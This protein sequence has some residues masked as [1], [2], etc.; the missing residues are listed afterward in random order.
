MTKSR[1]SKATARRYALTG[2]EKEKGTIIMNKSITAMLYGATALAG[3][4]MLPQSAA[5]QDTAP[6]A[7][8]DTGD[9][10]IIVT[11]RKRDESIVDV[12]LAITVV[13]SE[14]MDRLGITST[15]DLANFVPGLQFSDFTPGNSRNDRGG[16]RPLIFRGLNLA[17]NGGITGAGSMFLDGAAVIGNEIPG[18]Y[19]IGAVEVLRGPQSVYFGRAAMTG[20]VSYRTASIPNDLTTQANITIA[21]RKTFR[22]EASI[23]GPLVGDTLG[24][25]VTGLYETNDGFITNA[26]APTG[27]KFGARSRRSVSGTLNFTPS[28]RVNVKLYANYFS[29]DDGV[30]ATVNIFPDSATGTGTV[31][32]CL[33][34]PP[35][36]QNSGVAP[37][38]TICGRVPGRANAIAYSRLDIPKDHADILFNVPFLKG[39]RFKRTPGM[40]RNVFNAHATADFEI[41]DYL[42][43]T[44]I[45]GYHTNAT[46]QVVDGAQ[47]PI[48]TPPTTPAS[49]F[50]ILYF[51]LSNKF[52][53]F[54][55]EF[56]LAS[57]PER[58]FSWTVGATY[59]NAT[60]LSNAL[61]TRTTNPAPPAQPA[62]N[63]FIGGIGEDKAKTYGFFAGAYLKLADDRLT[64]SGEARYQI[65]DRTT[66]N[67]TNAGWP[68]ASG[69]LNTANDKFRSFTPR[70][71]I[72]YDVGNDRKV[73]A[74]IARGSR[75]GGF[76]TGLLTFFN[77]NN[78]VYTGPGA[79]S[80]ATVT[81]QITQ[82][83]GVTS[84]SYK[85]ETLTIGEL[86]FKGN[87]DG[88]KGYFDINLYYG[89]VGSQ[90]VRQALLVPAL[91]TTLSVNTNTGKTEVYGAEFTGNYNFTRD[92]SLN[93]TFA[94]N[95]TK[96]LAY[97]DPAPANIALYGFSDYS[98][99]ELPNAPEISGS[100]VLSY[101]QGRS[102][103]WSP[104]GNIALVYRGRQWA[105]I[106]NL[107]YV[108]G[109]ATVD[110][111]VGGK[112]E[113]FR[114]EAFVTNLLDNKT[115][116][117]GNVAPDFG[118]NPQ[119]SFSGFYGAYADPRTFGA[120]FSASF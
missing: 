79:P 46:T 22:V 32:N 18:G 97:I 68:N 38:A 45:T 61:N 3:A 21:E 74:S 53:D 76:N 96:R 71:S 101:E 88:N 118:G 72:D 105:D 48:I 120:R 90:Q 36:A 104:F 85:E 92:I 29:D 25:R 102:D 20:A 49:G 24:F 73:Y 62:F 87:L 39:E 13:S 119:G 84:P 44:S 66:N 110:L 42:S 43:L 35:A 114:V 50:S 52:K 99:L 41:S 58:A 89:K 116:P 64:L 54:S 23:A 5:A 112:N 55:Q 63:P 28:D 95:H 11:A 78:P 83:F 9:D 56:R 47:Q 14:K 67:Y 107:A 6:A 93:T 70:A 91:N 113:K 1:N 59:V 80:F 103:E 34:G 33:K 111:R 15:E 65:D 108:P 31:T 75:P 94:W 2:T 77:P 37:R 57:D 106:G 109:R 30:S 40:Q 19:D 12:P 7:A 98:G 17:G 4:T 8:E 69:L 115:Y 82:L 27:P 10:A 16:N 100:A 51:G 60:N 26:Y 81:G 86:G 117:G